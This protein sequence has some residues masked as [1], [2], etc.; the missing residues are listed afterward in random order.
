M[1]QIKQ[2]VEETLIQNDFKD[3]FGKSLSADFEYFANELRKYNP[4]ADFD[5]LK[6]V[7]AFACF[8]HKNDKRKSGQKYYVHFLWV[9]LYL[10]RKFQVYD[11]I[12]LAAA[13]LHDTIED[14][15]RKTNKVTKERILATFGSDKLA[16]VVEALTKISRESL[17]GEMG[18]SF[19]LI[20]EVFDNP[21]TAKNIKENKAIQKGLTYCKLLTTFIQDPNVIVIKL[22]DRYHNMQTLHYF[23][24][25]KEKAHALEKQ[26]EI[27]NETLQFYV[28]FA[29]RLGYNDVATE[30]QQMAF[31]YISDEDVH[32][33]IKTIIQEKISSIHNEIRLFEHIIN[34]VSIAN[35]WKELSVVVYHRPPYEVYNLTNKL[36]NLDAITDFVYIIIPVP[37]G[38]DMEAVSSAI[39]KNFTLKYYSRQPMQFSEYE[40]EVIKLSLLDDKKAPLELYLMSNSDHDILEGIAKSK[41]NPFLTK[42]LISIDTESL[43]IWGEWMIY[44]LL[45]QGEQ[46]IYNI[47]KSVNKNLFEDRIKCFTI[48]Q[49][50]YYLPIGS[51]SLD[52]AFS[53]SPE[54]GSRFKS[55]KIKDNIYNSDYILASNQTIQIITDNKITI[56]P[57]WLDFVV[58]Y[59]SIVHIFKYLVENKLLNLDKIKA[60]IE[61]NK[62]SYNKLDK[63]FTVQLY[64]K[65]FDREGLVTDVYRVFSNNS[66][67]KYNFQTIENNWFEGIL[68]ATFP[69]FADFNSKILELLNVR[70]VKIVDVIQIQY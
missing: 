11:E 6:R 4:D 27:S 46:A 38:I 52:F 8:H 3:G 7:F 43:N 21:V 56:E 17:E 49:Q 14:T 61:E 51:S 64:I 9:A 66:V 2:L 42:K 41:N 55:I 57:S 58:D 20:Q 12:Y 50:E 68:S 5:F 29:K 1:M 23:D 15:Q 37:E 18:M 70:S 59:R 26:R 67:G 34:K 13:F 45:L 28:G 25:G 44:N 48:D 60:Q 63:E 40:F 36:K 62:E 47:W 16:D 53:V 30:L 32:S 54:L 24:I 35:N 69:N 31:A 33:K 65:G 39:T 22:S 19:G 10:I